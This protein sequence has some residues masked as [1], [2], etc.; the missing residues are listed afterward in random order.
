MDT[1]LL[2]LRLALGLVLL[3][4]AAQKALGWFRG[5]GPAG[6]AA[7]FD[8]LGHRPGRRMTQLAVA[9]EAVSGVLLLLGLG[10]PLA[11]AVATGTMLV[12]AL[13]MIAK[14]GVFWNTLGGGEYPFLLAVMAASIGFAGPGRWSLDELLLG[15]W[16]GW[17]GPAAVLLAIVASAVPVSRAIRVLRAETPVGRDSAG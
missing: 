4:H 7:F 11:V 15:S 13:S 6:S 5:P 8:A 9:C 12:A 1:A 14:A 10:T 2:I 3:C 16:P 17:S